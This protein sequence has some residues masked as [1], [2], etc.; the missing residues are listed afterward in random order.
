[1]INLNCLRC[2]ISMEFI[3]EQSIGEK[4]AITAFGD[5]GELFT[6]SVNCLWYSCPQC[7]MI[8][9]KLK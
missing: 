6:E 4:S 2:N 1:M 5:L 8:E 9:L 7:R 3:K